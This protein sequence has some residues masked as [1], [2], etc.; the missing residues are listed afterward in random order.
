MIALP[1]VSFE[2]AFDGKWGLQGSY[3]RSSSR[4]N[5]EGTVLSD[6]G[7]DDAGTTQLYDFRGLQDFQSGFLP[8][9]HAHQ[10]KAFGSYAITE[11]L[12]IGANVQVISPRKYSC[13]GVNPNDPYAAAYGSASRYCAS[14]PA[15]RGTLIESDWLKN[16]DLSFRY[17]VPKSVTRVADVVLRAD[18]FNVFNSHAATQLDEL[19]DDDGATR[20]PTYGSVFS[21]QAPR[22][23]RVGFDLTF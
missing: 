12:L 1:E 2:R 19:Y 4:G 6:V 17:T 16:L 8:N 7:Q 10:F 9:H 11:N 21:Y 5:Y 20:L 15:R 22:S 23:L 3:V 14:E 18:L 13:L